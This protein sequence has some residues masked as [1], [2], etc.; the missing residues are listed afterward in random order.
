MFPA[1]IVASDFSCG[2]TKV[3]YLITHG[4]APHFKK[5]LLDDIV[6][7]MTGYT[8]HYDEATTE[9]NK[10]QMDLIIRYWSTTQ[11]KIT[12]HYLGSFFLWACSGEEGHEVFV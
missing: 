7:S 8:L 11:N 3:S 12:V 10:K 9:Q 1:N 5:L 2:S 6:K 4:L